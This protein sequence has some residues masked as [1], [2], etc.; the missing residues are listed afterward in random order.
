MATLSQLR[1]AQGS[2]MVWLDDVDFEQMVVVPIDGNA[3]IEI[4]SS[5]AFVT[6][7]GR[8]SLVLGPEGSRVEVLPGNLR[9]E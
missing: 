4:G 6:V 9:V 8:T 2:P 1:P 5:Y 3:D 7:A